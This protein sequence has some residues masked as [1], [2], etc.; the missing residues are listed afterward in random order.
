MS[1]TFSISIIFFGRVFIMGIKI[2]S[3]DGINDVKLAQL[4]EQ[5]LSTIPGVNSVRINLLAQK[6]TLDTDDTR[7]MNQIVN[8]AISALRKN[9]P[10]ITVGLKDV[11]KI[12]EPKPAPFPSRNHRYDDDD[13]DFL[14]DEPNSPY[15]AFDEY[16]EDNE[17]EDST[18]DNQSDEEHEEPRQN[19]LLALLEKWNLPDD[20]VIRLLE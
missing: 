7:D 20:T 3:I 18:T 15:A 14:P 10:G 9:V 6:L 1:P 13:D 12:P 2:L 5:L 17:N 11:S 19:K 16:A 4:L 8:E